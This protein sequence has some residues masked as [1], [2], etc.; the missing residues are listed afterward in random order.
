MQPHSQ[1]CLPLCPLPK[2]EEEKLLASLSC[3][4]TRRAVSGGAAGSPSESSCRR[5]APRDA[6]PTHNGKQQHSTNSSLAQ[7]IATTTVQARPPPLTP[8]PFHRP[9]QHQ[10]RPQ[11]PH[12]H[13]TMLRPPAHSLTQLLPR[14]VQAKQ[15]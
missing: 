14:R 11:A 12:P 7:S 3:V 15:R 6:L 8:S 1:S 9:S 4:A 2:A 13:A 5:E 10:P